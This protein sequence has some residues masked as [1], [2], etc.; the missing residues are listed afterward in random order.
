MR[1]GSLFSGVG[2][3]ELGLEMAGVGETIWQVEC[4]PFCLNILAKHWP[5]TK[6]INDV[7][8]AGAHNLEPVDLI[9]GGFPCQDVSG[10]GSSAGLSGDRSGL[11]YEF[12]RIVDEL[13]PT[14]VV[15]E[16]VSSGAGQWVDAIVSALGKQGFQTLP[17][18]ISAQAVGAPHLRRRVFVIAYS[19][20]NAVR[21]G[22]ER[23]PGRPPHRV[24][25]TGE[26]VALDASE[27]R[28]APRASTWQARPVLLRVDDGVPNRLDRY[29]AV[30]N[31][32]VPQCAEVVGWIIRELMLDLID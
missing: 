13:R 11:W 8:K 24:Q 22:T 6:R 28:T 4:E 9:V 3:L 32:V 1:I 31:A 14:W 7:K 19:E 26:G 2:G 25:G 5:H 10:A 27:A 30:G 16:N 20:R 23:Q 21:N 12:A 18:P 17:I 15:V 29:R